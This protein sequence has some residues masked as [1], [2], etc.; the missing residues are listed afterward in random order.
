MGGEWYAEGKKT[1]SPCL[2][3]PCFLSLHFFIFILKENNCINFSLAN[4]VDI[5]GNGK[6]QKQILSQL[7]ST[8][9][10]FFVLSSIQDPAK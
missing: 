8:R 5:K 6:V 1:C 7:L 9:S 2:S 4:P 10:I 3:S